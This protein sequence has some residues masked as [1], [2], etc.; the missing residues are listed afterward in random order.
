[1][2][3]I[4]FQKRFGDKTIGNLTLEAI[5]DGNKPDIYK[6]AKL[7]A[8]DMVL[9]PVVKYWKINQI[10]GE[11]RVNFDG[12]YFGNFE[13]YHHS[14]NV[15]G[16]DNK[17]CRSFCFLYDGAEL[18][19]ES[20]IV[21]HGDDILTWSNNHVKHTGYGTSISVSSEG[22]TAP[23]HNVTVSFIGFKLAEAPPVPTID[24]LII[25]DTQQSFIFRNF[26]E[27]DTIGTIN[28]S[29]GDS[30]KVKAGQ[31]TAIGS[32]YYPVWFSINGNEHY[33][34]VLVWFLSTANNSK[35]FL[36]DYVWQ[37][38][39]KLTMYSMEGS[40]SPIRVSG[41][42]GFFTDI[43]NDSP[44]NKRRIKGDKLSYWNMTE[45]QFYVFVD[46]EQVDILNPNQH[47]SD[48]PGINVTAPR[49]IL[50]QII[51]S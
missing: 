49:E 20:K 2:S 21:H 8:P 19:V 42:N 51:G 4:G 11:G 10:S 50:F 3:G 43:L 27:G 36:I 26:V 25:N 38:Q 32:F 48:V 15:A 39:L 18:A 29:D 46:G 35:E 22:Q 47:W 30:F 9:T 44:Q 17:Y 45:H 12:T 5:K 37:D 23:Y 40:T 13:I 34:S 14:N 6:M 41:F 1:M 24:I 28:P 16:S 33:G 31:M 7:F